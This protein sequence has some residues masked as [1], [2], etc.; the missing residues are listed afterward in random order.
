[1]WDSIGSMICLLGLGLLDRADHRGAVRALLRGI[2]GAVMSDGMSDEPKKRSRAWIVWAIMAA[3]VL[4]WAR[5]TAM[6]HQNPRISDALKSRA[7]RQ[8]SL[9]K[10][11]HCQLA[12]PRDSA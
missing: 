11:P 7:K 12:T 2:V 4:F 5:V 8:K 6:D 3:V 9:F 10:H 1:M